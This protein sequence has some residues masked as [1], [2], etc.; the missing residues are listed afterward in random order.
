MATVNAV[1]LK[2]RKKEDGTWRVFVRLTHKTKS[3]YIE[4]DYYAAKS[5]LNTKL[6]LKPSFVQTYVAA[7][8][9]DYRERLN[10]LAPFLDSMTV[11]QVK[12]KLISDEQKKSKSDYIDFMEFSSR[13]IEKVEANGKK[14]PA[15]KSVKNAVA[16]YF[17][18]TSV[19][20]A[21]INYKFL[22][23]FESYLRKGRK[24]QRVD[25]FG[26]KTV[27]KIKSLD[28]AGIN[29]TMSKLRTLFNKAR[30]LYNDEDSGE[31]LIKHYP[32]AKYKVKSS[33]GSFST[34]KRAV[35]IDTVRA[36]RDCKT[37]TQRSTLAKNMFMLSFYLCGMNSVDIY[38]HDGKLNN[39][40]IEYE[41]AKTSGRR[42][43]KAFISVKVVPEAKEI[44]DRFGGFKKRYA[45][46]HNFNRAINEGLR[47]ICKKLD[48]PKIDFYAA[49]HTFATIARNELRFSKDDIAATLN[50][51]DPDY[52]VTDIYIKKDFSI[53][54]E[55]QKGVI[56]FL[57]KE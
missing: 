9:T 20:I 50:H 15:L 36:I 53:I 13:Y 28:D 55:V 44:L 43:D 38:N 11:Q 19:N 51:V 45:D 10:R 34:E 16:D 52:R 4:T 2:H 32:F 49:R 42:A 47:S 12:E 18:S 14:V 29:N 46:A 27:T 3:A 48:I 33:L 39:G 40:R 6:Q 8:L 56:D 1:V 30:E 5:H 26:R 7:R 17:Q 35:E 23:S 54:D 41:R 57:N 31:L 25:Q 22:L 24:I 37:S 21:D